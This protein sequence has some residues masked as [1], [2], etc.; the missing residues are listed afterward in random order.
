MLPQEI[1][2]HKRNHQPLST[3]EINF[4]IKGVTDG[5]I[6]DCQI[7]ALTMAI[8]LN[9]FDADETTALT[10]AMRDS[11]DILRTGSYRWHA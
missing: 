4:F 10:A 6:A 1:I 8:F 2:R 5:S 9:G 3:E 7:G 11:G